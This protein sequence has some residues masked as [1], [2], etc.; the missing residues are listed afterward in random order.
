LR[1]H[2]YIYLIAFVERSLIPVGPA[3]LAH[4]RRTVH[5][6]SFEEHDKHVEEEKRRKDLDQEAFEEDDL[7]VGDEEE[8]EELLWSDPKEWK[9]SL[10]VFLSRGLS[11]YHVPPRIS[12]NKI[13]MQSSVCRILDIEQLRNR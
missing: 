6:L 9:V 8:T 11:L 7:G 12:R 3:Y 5:D 13:I 10:R 4:V 1:T 2:T